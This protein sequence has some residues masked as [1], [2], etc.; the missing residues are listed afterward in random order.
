MTE[1][2]PLIDAHHHFW[3]L[4]LGKHPWLSPEPGREMVFGDPA[5]LYRDYLSADLRADAAGLGLVGSVHIEAVWDRSDPVGETRWLEGLAQQTGLPTALVVFAPLDAPDLAAQLD[6]HLAA[7]SRVRGVRDI[8]A[9]HENP[10]FRFVERGDRMDDPAWRAGF[11][12][13]APLALSFDLMLFP[14][15][16]AQA[17]RLADAFPET[18]ILLNHAGSPVDRDPDGMARWRAGMIELGRRPNV[19]VKISD[20]VAYDHDWT[21]E[22]LRPVVLGCLDAFGPDRILWGSDFPVAGLHGSLRTQFEAV[23][24]I[25]A[26]LSASEMRAFRHDNAVRLYRLADLLGAST[27]DH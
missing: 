21:V 11:A 19:A 14:G 5:P 25:L 17:C 27:S 10:S 2:L 7:S 23:T 20:L 22:S 16:L 18:T 9:W 12:K 6:A 1:P 8:V 3:A 26:G 13:L 15:Q 24:A 4:E